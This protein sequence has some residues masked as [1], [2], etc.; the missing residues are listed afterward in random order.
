MKINYCF[1]YSN[2]LKTTGQ[3]TLNGKLLLFAKI[4]LISPK[5]SLKKPWNNVKKCFHPLR[6]GMSNFAN[7]SWRTKSEVVSIL[8]FLACHK[9]YG[10]NTYIS[11][12]LKNFHN[13]HVAINKS[14][15]QYY[16]T[17]FRLGKNNSNIKT[18]FI[19]LFHPQNGTS[20]FYCTSF[21]YVNSLIEM[22]DPEINKPETFDLAE[23]SERNYCLLCGKFPVNNSHDFSYLGKEYKV[24]DAEWG[25]LKIGLDKRLIEDNS[26]NTIHL[27]EKETLINNENVI[28]CNGL[29]VIGNDDNI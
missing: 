9:Q 18:R 13:A 22:D 16:Q 29:I 12:Y 11:Y 15:N 2:G 27:L 19:K 10:C 26:L 14:K 20:F 21:D 25:N 3:I 17:V 7:M 6:N 28:I 8:Y 1:A 4:Q 24:I 23:E 5:I